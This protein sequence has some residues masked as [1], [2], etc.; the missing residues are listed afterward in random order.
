[1]QE[2]KV[3]LTEPEAESLRAAGGTGRNQCRRSGESCGQV[4]SQRSHA[5]KSTVLRT[6]AFPNVLGTLQAFK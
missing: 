1:M 3:V 6:V 5:C 4:C 2:I